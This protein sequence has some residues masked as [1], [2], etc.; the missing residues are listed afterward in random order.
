[1]TCNEC[2]YWWP[3]KARA[4]KRIETDRDTAKK[5]ECRRIPPTTSAL[6]PRHAIFPPSERDH[7]CGE[8]TPIEVTE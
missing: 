6:D 5:G 8:F 3:F 4:F 1:M 7:W 2:Y